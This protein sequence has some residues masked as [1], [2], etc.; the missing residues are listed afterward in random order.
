M[1]DSNGN[2]TSVSAPKLFDGTSST[3]G[4]ELATGNDYGTN[5]FLLDFSK[6]GS[7]SSG[8]IDKVYDTAIS[9]EIFGS[10]RLDSTLIR[11]K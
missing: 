6:L 5:G 11:S 10:K 3:G 2:P 8:D 9:C 1:K 7:D 4:D